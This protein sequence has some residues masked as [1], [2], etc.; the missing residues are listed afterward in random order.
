VMMPEKTVREVVAYAPALG[1]TVT[2]YEIHLGETTGG[3][4]ARPTALINDRAD[5]ARSS[6]GRVWGT[7]IHGGT[8]LADHLHASG[9]DSRALADTALNEIADDL[10]QL[11][12]EAWLNGLFSSS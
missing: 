2:G 11:L 7:Y 4:C 1:A 10:A 8:M 12:D 9:G 6:C 3:D 5:G